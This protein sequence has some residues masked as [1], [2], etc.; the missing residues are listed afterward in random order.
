MSPKKT[1]LTFVTTSELKFNSFINIFSQLDT[2]WTVKRL[3]E[4]IPEIQ[5]ADNA[6][7]AKFSAHWAANHWQRPMIKEDVGWYLDALNGFP[8]PLVKNV[9]LW[10]GV[11][12]LAKLLASLPTN[13][14]RY[15]LAIAFCLPEDKPVAFTTSLYGQF[16]TTPRGTG[17]GSVA[18]KFFVPNR[19]RLTVAEQIDKNSFSRP[20]DHYQQLVRYLSS[21]DN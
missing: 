8:G 5:A 1:T 12:G 13:S 3:N 4:D 20:A 14:C 18:D 11:A 7:V 10:L 19:S 15:D 6:T 16:I 9:E 17:Q 21:L 2:K